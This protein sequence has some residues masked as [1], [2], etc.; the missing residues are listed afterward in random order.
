MYYRYVNI[1]DDQ[2]KLKTKIQHIV[3]NV[4]SSNRKIVERQNRYHLHTSKCL[5][6]FQADSKTLMKSGSVKLVLLKKMTNLFYVYFRIIT[7]KEKNTTERP[8]NNKEK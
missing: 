1:S 4:L 8:F 7:T 5:L 2:I 6:T 3:G